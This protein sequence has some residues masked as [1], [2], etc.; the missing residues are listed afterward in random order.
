MEA[1]VKEANIDTGDRGDLQDPVFQDATALINV[2]PMRTHHWSGV[3]SLI[4]N[5]IMFHPAP[6]EWHADSCADLAGLWDLPLVKGKTRLNVLLMLTPLF[7]SKGPH[8]FSKKY[9]WPYKG[10]LV[11]T[12][13]LATDALGL[14]ILKARRR[15]YFGEERP[16]SVSPKHIRVAEEKFGL[17][18]ADPARIELV[19][20]GL[21]RCPHLRDPEVLVRQR[22]RPV[23]VFV[24]VGALLEASILP[25]SRYSQT[26]L[27]SFSPVAAASSA[28][29]ARTLG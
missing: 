14:E 22:T 21:Q 17:G 10:L 5:Y 16:F 11:G 25:A 24:L 26:C 7:Q 13:P 4:K 20:L 3:G 2:R 6:P 29:P 15:E 8:A 23:H 12:D 19:K 18:V 27:T 28:S 9:T 1:G